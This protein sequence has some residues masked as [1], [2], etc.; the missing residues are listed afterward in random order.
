M[1]K[2]LLLLILIFCSLLCGCSKEDIENFLNTPVYP[3]ISGEY[4][5]VVEN[6]EDGNV[7]PKLTFDD[8][9]KEFTF[10]YDL[11]SSYLPTGKTKQLGNKMIMTTNDGK[12]KYVFEMINPYTFK[13][14]AEESSSLELTDA[15]LGI[16]INDGAI[17]Q[18]P[19]EAKRRQEIRQRQLEEEDT[20]IYWAY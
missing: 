13:F 15:S 16:Q 18:I 11:L 12:Y 3:N 2:T 1:K 9:K 7:L 8:Y 10:T 4:V 5:M 20:F 6:L 14:I 19:G 17:F